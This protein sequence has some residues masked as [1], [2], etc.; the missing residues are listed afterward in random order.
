MLKNLHKKS[1]NPCWFYL[2]FFNLRL[3]ETTDI[4]LIAIAKL[5]N[6][7]ERRIQKKGYKTQAAIGIHKEL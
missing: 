6:T 7:G 5:A 2:R 3:F 1:F 4:E